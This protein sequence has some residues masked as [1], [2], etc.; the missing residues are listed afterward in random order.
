M[1]TEEDHTLRE[2]VAAPAEVELWM[3][4]LGRVHYGPRLGEPKGIT[5]GVLHE[6]QFLHGV[7]ARAWRLDAFDEPGAVARVR[8]GDVGEVGRTGLFRG[9]FEVE[10]VAGVDHAGL[11]LPGWEHG[12][13]G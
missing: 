13:S 11:E 8:F 9:F 6:R 1:L 10:D 2:P 4:S 12:S 7:R 3:E 5:G